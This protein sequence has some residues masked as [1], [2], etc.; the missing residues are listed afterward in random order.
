[1]WVT[2]IPPDR[3]CRRVGHS[4]TP[5][6]CLPKRSSHIPPSSGHHSADHNSF[7]VSV[8]DFSIVPR[9]FKSQ[10]WQRTSQISSDEIFRS[11][12]SCPLSVRC[13]HVT[14]RIQSSGPSLSFSQFL[15]CFHCLGRE[16]SKWFPPDRSFQDQ[17]G[18]DVGETSAPFKSCCS[19]PTV[20][21]K[22]AQSDLW[23]E[24]LD[25]PPRHLRPE[26]AQG[27]HPRP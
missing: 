18:T 17:K 21:T 12:L 20:R 14:G 25:L 2:A 13:F 16:P 7:L 24:K 4:H 19:I 11:N 3:I 27:S 23:Q 9:A 6:Q 10:K 5:R 1:M 22:V 15:S 26:N 8:T